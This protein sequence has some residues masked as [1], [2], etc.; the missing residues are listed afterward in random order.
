[1]KIEINQSLHGY[2]NG[3]QLL[4]CSMKLPVQLKKILLFQTDLSGSSLS[5][6]FESYITGYPV[7]ESNV[8]VFSK[9]WYAD[10]MKRPGC[11]WTHSLL[12]SFT[13]LSL[14]ADFKNLLQLFI[15]P[16][17]EEYSFYDSTINIDVNTFSLKNNSK[18]IEN[19]SA[20]KNLVTAL[21]DNPNK[22]IIIPSS[23]SQ[24]FEEIFVSIWSDQW[25][26]LRRNFF[27]C[28]GSLSLKTFEEH[29]FDLQVSPKNN[30]L[31][32]ERESKNPFVINGNEKYNSD[33]NN[34]LSNNKALVRNFLWKYGSDI[35]GSR[36][37]FVPL[38]RIFD[39]IMQEDVDLSLIA[40]LFTKHFP[41]DKKAKFIKFQIFGEET[42]N[43]EFKF[44][45]KELVKFLITQEN[46]SFID[47][48]ELAIGERF[49]ALFKKQEISYVEFVEIMGNIQPK[50]LPPA[51]WDSISFDIDSLLQALELKPKFA[52]KVLLKFPN[53]A[54]HKATWNTSD[55]LQRV[56]LRSLIN[57]E[58]KEWRP[59]IEVILKS[60]SPI[61]YEAKK[62]LGQE[63][64]LLS[65]DWLNKSNDSPEISTDWF[66][67]IL[68]NN[69]TIFQNWL[70]KNKAKLSSNFLTT[71]FP[72][73]NY[74][75][76]QSLNFSADMWLKIYR[77]LKYDEKKEKIGNIATALLSI[78]LDNKIKDSEWLVAETFH[79]VFTFVT[80]N[81]ISSNFW[82][83][84]PTEIQAHQ[85]D[86]RDYMSEFFA[87]IRNTPKRK[88]IP[89]PSQNDYSEILIRTLVNKHIRHNWHHQA[90]LDAFKS[91]NELRKAFEYCQLFDK[92]QDFFLEIFQDI[93]K[94]KIIVR[95]IKR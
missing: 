25:P 7:E 70:S 82:T 39:A 68:F 23:S 67:Y 22:T 56:I 42:K 61:I 37:E 81:K 8:Y 17:V 85:V 49:V 60:G 2:Q 78:G 28:T 31:S 83:N 77:E 84:I 65:L 95:N 41:S 66:N 48:T 29:E 20:K 52:E 50:R 46:L 40:D 90:F 64:V 72:L 10:E 93:K 47:L 58:I 54:L 34:I 36:Q 26:R 44:S 33:W 30:I 45:E 32:L 92:G 75:E 13:D 69:K 51:V 91:E 73:L 62:E 35:E 55:L 27:F 86:E 76:I 12:I 53:I 87:L 4:G 89:L 80:T 3:H 16:K 11:V 5:K 21:Y 19:I 9:T 24:G 94:K 74:N 15:R 43:K 57:S 6:G 79:D 18:E 1:M 14:I 88:N 71:I 59:F 38:L 63:V